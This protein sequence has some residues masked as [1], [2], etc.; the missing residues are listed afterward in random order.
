MHHEDIKASIRKS[1]TSPAAIARSLKVTSA[2]VSNV[3]QGKTIS[4]RIARHIVTVT[5]KRF[6]ELW[7]GK[8]PAHEFVERADLPKAVAPG[9]KKKAVAA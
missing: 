4:A 8:Y 7:P 9:A 5:G 2:T 3:I 6:S 1:G